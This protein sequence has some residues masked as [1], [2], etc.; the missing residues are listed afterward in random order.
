M[1]PPSNLAYLTGILLAAVIMA[2][3]GC[4]QKSIPQTN[5]PTQEVTLAD[6][7]GQGGWMLFDSAPETYERG[8]SVALEEGAKVRVT[9]SITDGRT[10]ETKLCPVTVL[11]GK[12]TGRSGWVVAAALPGA[13]AESVAPKMDRDAVADKA[14]EA[15]LKEFR[16]SLRLKAVKSMMAG[17]SPDGCRAFVAE[18]ISIYQKQ[19][20][21]PD[22]VLQARV[23]AF[24]AVWDAVVGFSANSVGMGDTDK[25]H[26]ALLQFQ[27]FCA[28]LQQ[29]K[30]V[31]R[32]V[33]FA[34]ALDANISLI[35]WLV[36]QGADVN[37]TSHAGFTPLAYAIQLGKGNDAAKTVQ[38]LLDAGADYNLKYYK[39]MTATMFAAANGNA[40]V[41]KVLLSKSPDLKVVNDEGQ[42]ALQMAEVANHVEAAVLL[43]NAGGKK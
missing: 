35:N 14:F 15:M 13:S 27:P 3:S 9:G 33:L 24:N 36:K 42:T 31:Q 2:L 7:Q 21:S 28:E 41:L 4:G 43:E 8:H 40:D 29:D 32:E 1:K 25:N 34:A 23:C 11:S 10:P 39:G 37:M 22:Q 12:Y 18:Q 20:L 16:E 17:E 26:Q 30:D 19:N 38:A 5:D 6:S